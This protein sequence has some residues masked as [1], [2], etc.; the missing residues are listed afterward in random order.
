MAY[1]AKIPYEKQV[2]LFLDWYYA[3]LDTQGLMAKYGVGYSSVAKYTDKF[4][5]MRNEILETQSTVV[6]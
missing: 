2:E 6:A 4:W 1:P 5:P 3:R